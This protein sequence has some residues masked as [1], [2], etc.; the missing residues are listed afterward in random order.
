MDFL[1][2]EAL[3]AAGADRDER[4]RN[5]SDEVSL[6]SLEDD[7]QPTVTAEPGK[8]PFDYPADAGG[9]ELSV[10]AARSGLDRSA[11]RLTGLD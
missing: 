3:E 9:N 4:E 8:G 7:V 2:N 10:A 11:E 5:E 1:A 6:R